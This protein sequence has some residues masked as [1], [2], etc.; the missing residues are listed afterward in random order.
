MFP[1]HFSYS[2][3]PS[4][5][6][7]LPNEILLNIA[8]QITHLD[9][10]WDLANL[11]LVSKRWR[12]VAQEWLLKKP[13]FHIHFM[14]RYMCEVGK[15]QELLAQVKTVEIWSNSKELKERQKNHSEKKR[16]STSAT[17]PKSYLSL[18]APEC[19]TRD[20]DFMRTCTK[21]IQRKSSN[22][23]HRKAWIFALGNDAIPAL[24]SVLLCMLPNLRELKLGD[25]WMID[26]PFLT[27]ALST[28]ATQN[29][30]LPLDW[31]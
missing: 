1:F 18:S 12:A 16:E 30:V 25:A 21:I 10:N 13:R 27:A 17:G 2:H 14:Q 23:K 19:M 3:R 26:F 29:I 28:I 11:A 7:R 20:A 15:R 24:F 4:P 31:T 22:A 5:I 8:A 6:D 9:R